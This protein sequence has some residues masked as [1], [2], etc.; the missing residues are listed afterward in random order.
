MA[1]QTII[2]GVDQSEGAMAAA[3]KAARLAWGLGAEL[4]VVTA[5]GKYEF[6]AVGSTE[7]EVYI[8]SEEI[9]LAVADAVA[10]NLKGE[11]PDVVMTT[12]AAAGKPGDALVAVA[13]RHD[14]DVI[15]VGNKRVQG[16]ARVF[17]SIAHQVEAHASCDVYVA[18][19]QSRR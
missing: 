12:I 18:N 5:F 10:A 8:T 6:E 4:A 15:V 17:G 16:I 14:A 9:A 19:T 7:D 13:D 11:Y 1:A 3:R 2:V